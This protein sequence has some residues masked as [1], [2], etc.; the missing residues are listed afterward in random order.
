[1]KNA[2]LALLAV[3]LAGARYRFARGARFTLSPDGPAI[4][5]GGPGLWAA[6]GLLVTGMVLAAGAAVRASER[7]PAPL[8][9]KIG[10][11]VRVPGSREGTA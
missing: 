3:S 1:M 5:G 10:D 8:L 6:I 4:R 11:V 2:A 7:P 9:T